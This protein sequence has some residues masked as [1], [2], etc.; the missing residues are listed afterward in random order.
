MKLTQ[1]DVERIVGDVLVHGLSTA[2]VAK[3]FKISQRRVCSNLCNTQ[4]GTD[5]YLYSEN[6]ED[7]RMLNILKI[8]GKSSG[9]PLKD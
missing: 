8:S 5:C 6:Q 7:A 2:F 3:Q 4:E 1:K 9:R